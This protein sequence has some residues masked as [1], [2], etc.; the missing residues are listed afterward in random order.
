MDTSFLD[1]FIK[2][3][4][5]KLDSEW[6]PLNV[7]LK[8]KLA[9]NKLDDC[10]NLINKFEL[11]N[12][13]AIDIDY[14]KELD[15]KLQELEDIL[16]F[17]D[18][19]KLEI[20]KERYYRYERK[21]KRKKIKKIAD[22][23]SNKIQKRAGDIMN[24]MI[25]EWCESRSTLPI[26]ENMNDQNKDISLESP[27]GEKTKEI[28]KRE[29]CAL[30]ARLEQLR[31]I[32]LQKLKP[33]NRLFHDIQYIPNV[34]RHEEEVVFCDEEDE[35]ERKEEEEEED[36]Y[37]QDFYYQSVESLENFISIRRKWDKYISK[38]GEGG[39][40]IPIHFVRPPENPSTKWKK[41]LSE[42]N[43]KNG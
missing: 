14:Q 37:L 40:R 8:L 23:E 38:K 35:E 16:K 43:S 15:I 19:R 31:R 11:Q 28:S 22:R 39:T 20:F 12:N 36:I 10:K 5:I 27:K 1:N 18:E 21:R 6:E 2:K 25:D 26:E 7:K 30:I 17:F 13:K 32:R 4:Q 34:S 24:R 3:H 42:E 33:E 41:F 29:I 9:L